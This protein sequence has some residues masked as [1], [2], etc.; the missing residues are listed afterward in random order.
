[1]EDVSD[2]QAAE[3]ATLHFHSRC[4]P[5]DQDDYPD[6]EIVI[7]KVKSASASPFPLTCST[8][9]A[10]SKETT[11]ER[12]QDPLLS[13]PLGYLTRHSSTAS[14]FAPS[15]DS[16]PPSTHPIMFTPP[17]SNSKR[18]FFANSA[19][20]PTTTSLQQ[21]GEA[22]IC[23]N[24][25]KTG[26]LPLPFSFSNEKTPDQNTDDIPQQNALYPFSWPTTAVEPSKVS[27]TIDSVSPT[28]TS[29]HG[30]AFLTSIPPLPTPTSFSDVRR[31]LFPLKDSAS[32]TTPLTTLQNNLSTTKSSM[33]VAGPVSTPSAPSVDVS[34]PSSPPT[35][36]V[37]L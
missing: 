18:S 25:I 9:E 13:S 23:D 7:P 17:K 33:T 37:L 12:I 27:Q 26:E 14:F 8:T 2:D 24:T 22:F 10:A 31:V 4:E 15:P 19:V 29:F 30:K 32:S 28:L 5:A 35:Y 1:M 20:P 21:A 36:C 11:G 34:S 3:L 16:S 6:I